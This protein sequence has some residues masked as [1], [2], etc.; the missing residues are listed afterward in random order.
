M[1]DI[2]TYNKIAREARLRV[3]DMI[4]KAQSS[5]IG[6]NFSCID[7]LTVLHENMKEEDLIVYSKGWVAASA[8]YF[9]AL[10]GK[11]PMEELDNFCVEGSPYI[12]L[13]E[14][15]VTGITCAGGSMG[16]GLPF[17][18][19]FAL[20]KK[21]KGDNGNIY[22]LMSDG[23]LNCGTVWEAMMI[24]KRHN[25]TNIVLIIDKNSL[26]GMG[27]TKDVL[28]VD[29]LVERIDSFGWETRMTMG[30]DYKRLEEAIFTPYSKPVCVVANTVKG[31]GVSFM[32]NDNLWHYKA[33]NKDEYE[34]AKLELHG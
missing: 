30:H 17:A 27:A 24:A 29:N 21:L 15:T 31:K 33:P 28:D 4:Y 8:Y 1:A 18:V 14:P 13:V 25:L 19:G 7:I 23:E 5:H 34:K 3:L 10:K 9:L 22:V 20:T 6:S 11:I 12:G 32:E 2:T 16:Y 26:Q